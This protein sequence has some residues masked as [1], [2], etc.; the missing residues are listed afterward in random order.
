M[1]HIKIIGL[2]LAAI[3]IAYTGYTL[4][5][6]VS[7]RK[8]KRTQ[9]DDILSKAA[10]A[11]QLKPAQAI[12]DELKK[13]EASRDARAMEIDLTQR[14]TELESQKTLSGAKQDW[15]EEKRKLEVAL[16]T[17]TQERDKFE[18]ELD[19][20]LKEMETAKKKQGDTTGKIQD[21]EKRKLEV[22]LR[23]ATQ[24]RD[25]F[26]KELVA[27]LKEMEIAQKKQGDTGKIQD[28]L[29]KDITKL[30]EEKN[31]LQEENNKCDEWFQGLLEYVGLGHMSLPKKDAAAVLSLRLSETIPY[32]VNLQFTAKLFLDEYYKLSESCRNI[33]QEHVNL[34]DN[35]LDVYPKYL[36]IKT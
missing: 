17:A 10:T 27:C 5:L 8:A 24:E 34:L 14:K 25:R 36:E 31:R 18:K 15:Q 32:Y 12:I 29:K 20:C 13:T 21:E 16:S 1:K 23:T 30:N 19:A 33:K 26:E 7:Q 28:D 4:S 22:A 2:A 6:T 3:I 11:D 9:F 35:A